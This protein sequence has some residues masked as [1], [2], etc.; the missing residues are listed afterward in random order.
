MDPALANVLAMVAP[1]VVAL[2]VKARASDT[3]RAALSIVITVGLV[4]ATWWGKAH[5]DQWDAM[6]AQAGTLVAIT[7]GVYKTVDTVLPSG[8]NGTMA[9]EKG[10]LG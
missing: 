10:V 6:L 5:P 3:V 1:F 8:L 2:L 4:V 9:P 7:M